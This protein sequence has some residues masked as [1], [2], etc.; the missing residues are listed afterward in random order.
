MT[1]EQSIDQGEPIA[2][3]AEQAVTPVDPHEFN[4]VKYSPITFA[5]FAAHTKYSLFGV[6]R[7]K[8][9]G[10][11]V[12]IL[13][14]F[15]SRKLSF[16]RRDFARRDDQMGEF[17]FLKPPTGGEAGPCMAPAP[18]FDDASWLNAGKEWDAY[19][20]AKG[21]ADA[22]PRLYFYGTV[23]FDRK[24]FRSHYVAL[25]GVRF[26]GAHA[27]EPLAESASAAA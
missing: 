12:V 18:G 24:V 14:T 10:K 4:G 5:E 9:S 7:Y 23:I 8:W 17:A 25:D 26:A 13:S 1:E 6:P 27:G 22:V 19:A 2:E 3:N 11:Q 21:L 20:T 15:S 16:T